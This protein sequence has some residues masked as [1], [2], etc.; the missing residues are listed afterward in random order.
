MSST[1]WHLILPEQHLISVLSSNL[2]DYAV[3]YFCD[4]LF[5]L[6]VQ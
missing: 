5:L 6:A 2:S 1:Y 3:V 4:N